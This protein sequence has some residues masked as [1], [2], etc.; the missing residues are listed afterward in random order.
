MRPCVKGQNIDHI[1]ITD[2]DLKELSRPK[3]EILMEKETTGP[4]LLS[5]VDRMH[6][7]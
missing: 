6:R 7:H 2:K 4:Q 3:R 1:V 5:N